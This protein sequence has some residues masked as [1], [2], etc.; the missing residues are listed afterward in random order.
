MTRQHLETQVETGRD[1][2]I[3]GSHET[4]HLYGDFPKW[5]APGTVEAMCVCLQL[6]RQSEVVTFLQTTVDAQLVDVHRALRLFATN[7][8]P[9]NRKA[10]TVN[11]MRKWYHTR[12]VKMTRSDEK[13]LPMITR[14]D[15]QSPKT[16][17]R[18]HVPQDPE[19]RLLV[20][21]V[22]ATTAQWPDL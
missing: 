22:L 18:Y 10:P 4:S 14:I 9:D 12:L 17:S 1:Y 21:E 3:F 13:L 11:L 6:P 16:A 15:A 20:T 2:M 19:A 5:L 7:F 8:L